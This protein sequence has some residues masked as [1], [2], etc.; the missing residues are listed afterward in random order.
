[1]AL[2][3]HSGAGK[4]RA[5]LEIAN[6]LKQKHDI[7]VIYITFNY[8]TG[9]NSNETLYPLDSLLSRIAY[10]IADP[11][12]IQGRR[13]HSNEKLQFVTT[14]DEITDWLKGNPC[15]LCIDELNSLIPAMQSNL[16][17]MQ[18]VARFLKENFLFPVNRYFIFTSHIN[19][20]SRNLTNYMDSS[21]GRNVDVITLPVFKNTEEVLEVLECCDTH[22]VLYGN[23]PGLAYSCQHNSTYPSIR[24]DSF[25]RSIMIKTPPVSEVIENLFTGNSIVLNDFDTF[26]RNSKDVRIWIPAFLIALFEK[27]TFSNFEFKYRDRAVKLL[28]LLG[29]AKLGSGESWEI[30]VLCALYFRI[31]ACSLN[32]PDDNPCPG[33]LPPLPHQG[34]T[35]EYKRP[36][37]L[38]LESVLST[39]SIPGTSPSVII[40]Y[41]NQS[42]FPTYDILVAVT[43]SPSEP[44]SIWGYQC[45]AGDLPNSKPHTSVNVSIVLR[46]HDINTHTSHATVLGWKVAG[47]KD[48][49][50]LL[51]PTFLT[52]RLLEIPY[53]DIPHE[54]I[55]SKKREGDPLKDLD[56]S[57]TKKQNTKK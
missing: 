40:S 14:E 44:V 3:A 17:K 22:P 42:S 11:N 55:K 57:T 43:H 36:P 7:P 32:E 9:Y 5:L 16:P 24:V 8:L 13:L 39:L 25:L 53:G 48:R 50:A 38:D 10:A 35:I 37:E 51:G 2:I 54:N 19:A 6:E 21:S 23:S 46:S 26:S 41:P 18:S 56:D 20:T 27:D 49:N 31:L 34:F 15:L 33:W 52:L 12:F 45:K 29:T 30:V 28:K 47:K 1:M 4:T